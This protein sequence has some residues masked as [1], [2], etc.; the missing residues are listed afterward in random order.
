[1]KDATNSHSSIDWTKVH[2]RLKAS[3][4]ALVQALE[5]DE[6]RT[7]AIQKRRA[8]H[9]ANRSQARTDQADMAV[10]VFSVCNERFAIMLEHLSEIAGATNCTPVPGLMNKLLGLS[11]LHGEIR[12]VLDTASLLEIP[13][14]GAANRT[15][16]AVLYLRWKSREI[17]LG[18]DHLEGIKRLEAKQLGKQAIEGAAMPRRYIQAITAEA[19]ALIDVPALLEDIGFDDETMR[20][21]LRA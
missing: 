3:N 13:R 5:P 8:A 18:A 4:Q 11:S 21:G 12:P 2:E 15:P 10:L 1:M 9:L 7:R 14:Q 6:A 20:E 16:G 17:G 19:L